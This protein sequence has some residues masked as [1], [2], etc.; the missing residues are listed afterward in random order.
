MGTIDDIM[1]RDAIVASGTGSGFGEAVTLTSPAGD[2]VEIAAVVNRLGLVEHPETEQTYLAAEVFIARGET[3]EV[4][5]RGWRI[6]LPMRDGGPPVQ[7]RVALVL[8][9]DPAGVTLEVRS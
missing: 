5:A 1:R 6:T 2:V 4:P 7:A 3:L 9:Q 8:S